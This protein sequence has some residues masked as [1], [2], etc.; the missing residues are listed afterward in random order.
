MAARRG[1]KFKSRVVYIVV[2]GEYED[3]WPVSAWTN[4]ARAE[5]A[6]DAVAANLDA[7]KRGEYDKPLW[8]KVVPV[9]LYEETGI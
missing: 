5:K 4:K 3:S 6:R 1:T 8:A 7:H 2:V 9:N